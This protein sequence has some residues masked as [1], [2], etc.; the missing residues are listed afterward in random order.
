MRSTNVFASTVLAWAQA[1]STSGGIA[2]SANPPRVLIQDTIRLVLLVKNTI[3][4]TVPSNVAEI[5][6]IASFALCGPPSQPS[7]TCTVIL[8]VIAPPV[9][10]SG[11]RLQTAASNEARVPFTAQRER[12]AE[13]A[14]AS[15]GDTAAALGDGL[16]ASTLPQTLQI[17]NDIRVADETVEALGANAEVA[18]AADTPPTSGAQGDGVNA[19]A[20]T[21]SLNDVGG[22][23]AQLT[24]NLNAAG[25]TTAANTAAAASASTGLFTAVPARQSPR[26]PPFPPSP[27]PPS[28]TPPPPFPDVPLPANTPSSGD[29]Q[30]TS[31]DGALSGGAIAGIVIGVLLFLLICILCVLCFLN[32]AWR[33]GAMNT[34]MVTNMDDKKAFEASEAAG[35]TSSKAD[36]AI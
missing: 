21:G 34:L 31:G 32:P 33:K 30:T 11:R 20:V 26:L 35:S 24:T 4:L 12:T 27:P 1:A 9:A 7:V 25:D 14:A 23:E 5:T 18:T 8:G 2:T 16:A 22:L 15:G 29:A 3:D 28:P 6:N 17:G 36:E 10:V 13:Q 19:A